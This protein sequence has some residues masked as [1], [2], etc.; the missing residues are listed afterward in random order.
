MWISR[1]STVGVRALAAAFTLA[2]MALAND[3]GAADW[4]NRSVSIVVP[5]APGGGTDIMARLIAQR[6]TEKYGKP[7]V[8]DNRGGASGT[9]GSGYVA[10]AAADGYTLLYVGA[11]PTIIVPMM[12]KVP[13]DAQK[14]LVPISIFGTGNYILATKPALPVKSLGEFITYAKER[15]GKLNYASVGPGGLQHLGIALLAQRAGIDMVHVPFKSTGLGMPDLLK[16]ETNLI[17]GG[18]LP[19]LPYVQQGRLRALAVTTAK[20]SYSVPEVPTLSETMPGF[21]V[22]SWFGLVAPKRTPATLITRLNEAVN[23]MLAE[24]ETKKMIDAQGLGASG[25]TPEDFGALIRSDHA[26]A[27]KVVKQANIKAQ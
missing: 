6:L 3:A 20:R 7:F 10:R 17:L 4:P 9:I 2:A 24:P 19:I 23:R 11:V 16:G 8:V 26:R 5:Y 27:L 21:E 13:Y 1:N 18:L 15:P 14:E 22:E 12:Q 25:G